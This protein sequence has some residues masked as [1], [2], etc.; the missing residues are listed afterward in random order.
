MNLT[1]QAIIE[2]TI[3]KHHLRLQYDTVGNLI[4]AL[5][6]DGHKIAAQTVIIEMSKNGFLSRSTFIAPFLREIERIQDDK[7]K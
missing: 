5:T 1:T 6:E 4:D 3:K 7:G 2:Q